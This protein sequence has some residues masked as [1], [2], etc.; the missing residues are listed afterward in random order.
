LFN[1]QVVAGINYKI[2]LLVCEKDS[3]K[4]E[5]IVMDHKVCLFY[6]NWKFNYLLNSLKWLIFL[7]LSFMWCNYMGTIMVEQ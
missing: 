7:E 3:T 1:F 2:K 6:F 4:G 5:D